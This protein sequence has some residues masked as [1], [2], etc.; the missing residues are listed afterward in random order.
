ME[1]R[2]P[3]ALLHER[4]KEI[5]EATETKE[6]VKDETEFKQELILNDVDEFCRLVITPIGLNYCCILSEW[7]TNLVFLQSGRP[8]KR[9][10][11]LWTRK[12]DY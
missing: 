9:R 8:S 5:E 6:D 3:A 10:K 1:M 11:D 12:V 7:F 4:L 2:D